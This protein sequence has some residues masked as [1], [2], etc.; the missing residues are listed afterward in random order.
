MPM[1]V[2]SARVPTLSENSFQ[3]SYFLST[4]SYYIFTK[5]NVINETDIWISYFKHF[6]Y[7]F[8]KVVAN[9]L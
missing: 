7:L 8:C 1:A 6:S 3:F 4:L 2:C 5:S 9:W